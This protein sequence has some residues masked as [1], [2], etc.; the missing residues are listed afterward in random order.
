MGNVACHQCQSDGYCIPL[1]LV[2]DGKNQC[3]DK[4]DE[5][6]CQIHSMVPSETEFDSNEVSVCHQC[7][8]GYC[9]PLDF[10]CDGTSQCSD[11]SDEIFCQFPTTTSIQPYDLE[12][13]S[14]KTGI[15]TIPTTN[16]TIT[17]TTSTMNTTTSITATF[18]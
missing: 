14:S 10:I 9:I 1:H 15:T 13:I 17:T 11:Q 16:T 4:S 8:L 2:C 3:S 18:S 12:G 5:I 7:S 6:N